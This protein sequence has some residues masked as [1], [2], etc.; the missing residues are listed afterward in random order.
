MSPTDQERQLTTELQA[1]YAWA[2][3]EVGACSPRCDA[4]GKCC[5]FKEYGHRLYLCQIEARHL[6]QA[7]YVMARHAVQRQIARRCICIIGRLVARA[8]GAC[9]QSRHFSTVQP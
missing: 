5:R 2:D 9:F 1:L 8:L 6:L 4:S 7:A 3:A